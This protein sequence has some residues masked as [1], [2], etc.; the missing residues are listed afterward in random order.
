[1]S[2][3]EVLCQVCN[4]PEREHNARH[5]FTPPGTRVDTAQFARRRRKFPVEGNDTRGNVPSSYSVSQ[6]ATPFDPVLRQ[7]LIDAGV[8]TVAQLDEAR[9]KIEAITNHVMGGMRGSDGP[10]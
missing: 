3:D 7:A 10:G 8:I 4:V 9:K 1:M 6:S 5:A 2:E